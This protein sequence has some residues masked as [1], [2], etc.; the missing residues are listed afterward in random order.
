M[1]GQAESHSKVFFSRKQLTALIIPLVLEQILGVTVGM[2][3]TVM[4]S[5]AGEAAVSGVSLV[6]NI[7][8]LLVNLFLSL[9][10]G[11]SGSCSWTEK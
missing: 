1:E 2:A 7:N 4:V 5:R 10:T 11:G 6:D 9:S 3:D 8:L